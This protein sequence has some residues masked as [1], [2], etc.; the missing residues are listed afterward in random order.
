MSA[1]PLRFRN[2]ETHERLRFIAEQLGTSMNQLVEE[3]IE[4]EISLLSAG[5]ESELEET[6]ARLR[7][8]DQARIDRSLDEWAEAEGQPDPIVTHVLERRE[9]PYRIAEAFGRGV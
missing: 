9:D 5:L 7:S 6:L 4:R 1:F 8:F 3:M 2:R